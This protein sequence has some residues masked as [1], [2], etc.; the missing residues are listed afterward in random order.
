MN[1]HHDV[2]ESHA[3]DDI[4]LVALNEFL[5]QLHAQVGL[6]LVVFFDHLNSRA[7]QFAAVVFHTEHESV[8]LVLAQSTGRA[9]QSTQKTDLHRLL[10]LRRQAAGGQT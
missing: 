10:R 5:R 8:V 1:G 2:G 9:G 4:D 6:E 3:G 7:A